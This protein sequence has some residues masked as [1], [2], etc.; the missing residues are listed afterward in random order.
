MPIILSFLDD[1]FLLSSKLTI[2]VDVYE[3]VWIVFPKGNFDSDCAFLLSQICFF[4]S[5]CFDKLV[6][7]FEKFPFLYIHGT[8]QPG[9]NFQKKP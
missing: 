2:F 7:V 4:T 3:K 8:T 9:S 6:S 1:F 5:G